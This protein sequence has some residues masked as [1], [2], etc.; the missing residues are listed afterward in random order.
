MNFRTTF[1][2]CILFVVSLWV[3]LIIWA[4]FL[5]EDAG[6]NEQLKISQVYGLSVETVQRIRLSLKD[7][8]YHPLSLVKDDNGEWQLTD[9]ISAYA[10]E[11]KVSEM[12]GDLL[13]KR[14]KRRIEVAELSQYGL[15]PP[16]IQIDLWQDSQIS[17]TMLMPKGVIINIPINVPA[18]SGIPTKSFLI[19]KKTVNYSVYAKEASESHI[20]L[21]ESSALQDLTKSPADF[22]TRNVLRFKPDKVSGITLAVAG[23]EQIRC[24]MEGEAEWQMVAPIA[25]KADTKEIRSILDALHLLKVVEFIKDGA[26]DLAQYGLEVPRIRIILQLGD[27]SQELRVGSDIPN[28]ARIYVKSD[29]LDAV[30][31]VNREIFSTL[32]KS[33]F[34]LRDKR[35]IDFQ[36]TATNR[37]EIQGRGKAKIACAKDL[38]GK[39]QIE[40]PI[41]LKADA[42]IVDDILFG[43]DSLKAVEFVAEQPKNL[44]RYGLDFPS[45]QISFFTQDAEPAILLLGR[46]KGDT[47]YTKAQNAERVVLVN[48]DLLELIGLGVAGLRDKQVLR[49]ESDEAFKLTLRLNDVQLTCQ[50]Q[51]ANWRL[52]SPVQ[53]DA[54]NGAV[55]SIV[56]RLSDLKVEKFLASA[57]GLNVTR[58]YKPEV[59]ATVTLK[60]LK[61]YTLQIGMANENEQRYARLRA[62]PDTV[63]LLEP[64][65]LDELRKTVADLRVSPSNP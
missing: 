16:T 27:G 2:I 12:L 47:V 58:L 10:N 1:F 52:V 31:A 63:F 4:F 53:E 45:L 35:V 65:I 17:T 30:Y 36:R 41:A 15:D 7:P 42:E 54:N 40:E 20:F 29:A 3:Y 26:I 56:Y 22:R 57:P 44:S 33:V 60:N 59:Q 64:P 13:N 6:T 8:A 25:V 21:I 19:G 11:A 5:D 34:D 39:W 50:K 28:T 24:Q 61:E 48:S 38:K 62:V 46:I 18:H 23:E 43:V 55:N 49:F 37:F 14:V 32:H 51:G 9:P